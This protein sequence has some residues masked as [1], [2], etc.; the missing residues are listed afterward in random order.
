MNG[1]GATATIINST[2]ANNG[3]ADGGGIYLD[4][5]TVEL[6]NVTLSGNNA[7]AGANGSNLTRIAGTLTITNTL[8]KKGA[9]GQNC[10][11]T[12]TDGGNN[13]QFGDN[14]CTGMSET[15]TD[16]L[17]A[18]GLVDNG[19]P[20]LTIA[21]ADESE[22]LNAGDDTV[23]TDAGTVNS[24]DQRGE[25]RPS[26]ASCDIGAFEFQAGGGDVTPPTVTD[27][28]SSKANGTYTTGEVII[29]QVVFDEA[30]TVTGT[31]QITLETGSSDAVVDYS[32]G[33]GTDTITF[34]YTVGAG[35]TSSD[36]DYIGTDSLSLNGGTI[37]DAAANN[38]SL[39]L[40]APGA[41]GSLGN[42][43]AIVIDTTAPV[44]SEVT[45]VTTPT[46][47]TTP[48]YTF[49]SSEGGTISYG[50]SCSS[51]TSSASIGNN[52]ITFN[53][54]AVGTYSDCTITVTDAVGN[55]SLALNV[56]SFTI[57][58]VTP[59][60]P[61][62]KPGGGGGAGGY[63]SSSQR[64]STSRPAA[65]DQLPDTSSPSK[66]GVRDSI[67]NDIEN[68][69][70]RHEILQISIECDIKGYTDKLGN[71]LQQFRPNNKITR[72]EFITMLMKCK[73][74]TLPS[75][76]KK[77]FPDVEPTHPAAPYIE[78]GVETGVI[79]GY[80]DGTFKPDR[81][82]NLAET[83]KMILLSDI[84]EIP[85][86][87]IKSSLPNFSCGNFDSHQYYFPY[88]NYALNNKI[89]FE[90][91]DRKG[92]Q[93]QTCSPGDFITRGQAAKIIIK[94]KK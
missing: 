17:D 24:I 57:H 88:M 3:S 43:K 16:P 31:P 18:A 20:T 4:N 70:Y 50:G 65:P 73:F 78:K 61:T 83:L 5:G 40:P 54:L 76:S 29:V 35:H 37:Q 10:K 25:V 14:T 32:G 68:S 86:K 89:I 63:A 74:G 46:T 94:F 34:N 42:N 19:G 77:I 47:N 66:E 26:G 15:L 72:S 64:A 7:T 44:L 69:T 38:A 36:L 93:I 90:V 91:L 60:Q 9:T 39:T 80:P 2:I 56:S 85:L 21:L 82:T 92:N 22:A 84:G 62:P 59:P 81:Y 49:S 58:I 33:S 28:T 11:G 51:A 71:A 1:A 79:E 87:D 12:V 45:P 41:I 52:T 55:V 53:T 8:L 67:F 13:L 27:V 75:S 6:Y 30:V 48:S 23:C